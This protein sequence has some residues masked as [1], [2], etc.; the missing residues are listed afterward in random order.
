MRD[1][2]VLSSYKKNAVAPP[3]P[4]TGRVSVNS[5]DDDIISI[6]FPRIDSQNCNS[7][8]IEIV[9]V[10]KNTCK[11]P[12]DILSNRNK[13]EDTS[14]NKTRKIASKVSS[15]ASRRV[16]NVPYEISTVDMSLEN[17]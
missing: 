15:T 11:H 14:L 4:L 1:V 3:K 6:A 8:E 16:Q 13:S 12:F 5:I 9:E 7:D 10:V 17:N 2:S